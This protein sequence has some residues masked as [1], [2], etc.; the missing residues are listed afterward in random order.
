MIKAVIFDWGG[1]IAPNPGG[2]WLGV[3]ADMLNTTVQEILPHW[4]AAGYEDLSRGTIDETEFFRL[5]KISLGKPLPDG[6]SRIWVDGSAFNP[7]PEMLTFIQKLKGSGLKVALL[8]NTVKPMSIVA[9]E[10]GLYD[11]FVPL[12]LSDVVGSVKPELPIYQQ[13]LNELHLNASECIYI[14]DLQRNLVPA[15][16]L[17]MITV[18]A[19][20][21]P[22]QTIE[23]IEQ[24]ISST[25]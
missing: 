24:A 1:V 25:K 7:W 9:K 16:K 22:T 15:E 12:I 8:S 3:L 18:L 4:R 6:V 5:F 13:V 11:G 20:E 17:G 14:D 21:D 19:S 10:K 23:L 2:G